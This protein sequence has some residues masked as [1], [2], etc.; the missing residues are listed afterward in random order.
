MLQFRIYWRLKLEIVVVE[1]VLI[2]IAK[3]WDIRG[4]IDIFERWEGILKFADGN[5]V[6]EN[7]LT[8]VVENL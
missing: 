1:I 4:F 7:V 6:A 3:E 8:V 2:F 5:L